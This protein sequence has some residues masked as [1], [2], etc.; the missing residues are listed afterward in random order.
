[1]ILESVVQIYTVEHLT[2]TGIHPL[3]FPIT[4]ELF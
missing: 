3:P 4:Q 2:N 1:M